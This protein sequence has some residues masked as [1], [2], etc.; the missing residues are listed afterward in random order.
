MKNFEKMIEEFGQQPLLTFEEEA[1]LA[2]KIKDGENARKRL[3]DANLRF[4]VA[5]AKQYQNKG[6][7][8]EEL[9]N[10][11]KAGLYKATEKFDETLGYKFISFA[12]W[13]VRQSILRAVGEPYQEEDSRPRPVKRSEMESE[14][15]N[16]MPLGHVLDGYEMDIINKCFGI[17]CEEMT[18]ED[19]GKQIGMSADQVRQIRE[20]SIEKLRDSGNSR[21]ILDRINA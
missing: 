13:W 8:I 19:I 1:I 7:T 10:A 20:N 16:A 2:G 21:Y 15:E 11:G 3:V 5:I 4:I 9:I 17:G 12:E 18:L 14:K 6:L